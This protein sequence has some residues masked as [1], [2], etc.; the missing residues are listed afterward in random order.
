M[1]RVAT[2]AIAPLR[3]LEYKEMKST[4]ISVLT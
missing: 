3:T 1:S 2:N 4:Y